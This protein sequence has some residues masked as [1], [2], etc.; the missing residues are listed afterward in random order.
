MMDTPS[1]AQD[2]HADGLVDVTGSATG[3]S[4]STLP[5]T[6]KMTKILACE[7]KVMDDAPETIVIKIVT[8]FFQGTMNAFSIMGPHAATW[9]PVDGKHA[10]IFGT[11]N[12]IGMDDLASAT[13]SSS[14]NLYTHSTL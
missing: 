4:A 13:T 12:S 6:I 2:Q 7:I 11:E 5:A 3:T 9:K 8:F 1:S 14:N 10:S